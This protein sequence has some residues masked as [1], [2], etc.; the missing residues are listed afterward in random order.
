MLQKVFGFGSIAGVIV[1]IPLFGMAVAMNGQPPPWYGVALGYATMLIA[2]TLVFIAIKR[3]RDMDLGGVIRF[4]P[5]FGL[6]LG[7]SLVA[8]IFY[9]FAWE[10]ALVVTGMDFAGDYTRMLIEQQRAQGVTD[11]ALAE[12]T[13]EMQQF[14]RK[15]ANPLYRIP[16]TFIEIFPIG[17]LVSLVS[18][19]LLKNSRFLPARRS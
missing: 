16:L 1:A 9:V 4:W 5:A 7:I 18:A 10:A 15:Y 2:L 17:V 14:A 19:G 13:A 11:E 12:F 8:S 6:G 3:H